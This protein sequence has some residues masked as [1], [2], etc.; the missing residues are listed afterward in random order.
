MN[1][2]ETRPETDYTHNFHPWPA[3]FPPEAVTDLIR[4]NTQRYE[5]VLDPFC[6]SGTTLVECRLLE[7]NAIGIELNPVGVLLSQ[8]KSA[9]YQWQDLVELQAFLEYMG[10]KAIFVDDWLGKIRYEELMPEYPRRDEWFDPQILKE[11]AGLKFEIANR[12]KSPKVGLLLDLAFSR[13]V[14][15]ISNQ[16]SETHYAMV[17]KDLAK[18]DAL[19][20]FLRVAG[21]YAK[22]LATDVGDVSDV[23][24]IDVIEGDTRLVLD[25]LNSESVHFV[26]TSPPYINSYDYYLYNKHRIYWMGKDPREVRRL[27][28]GG[29]HTI[30]TKSYE[31]ALADY[32]SD[33]QVTFSKVHRVLKRGRHFAILI[34]DGIVKGRL[35]SG[36][37]L[38]EKVAGETSFGVEECQSVPLRMVSKRFIKDEKIDRKKH[39]IILLKAL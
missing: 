2:S 23:V 12:V 28:I 17:T 25:R 22:N 36:S 19:R 7:R 33:L 30:D 26:V 10:P 29:H 11:L 24:R 15:P 37:D 20:M 14:V 34:G 8:A 3:K 39:H 21:S 27:E 5:T 18:G 31:K 16:E 32:T 9:A 6:G 13:I 4:D 38:V 35:V 1:V